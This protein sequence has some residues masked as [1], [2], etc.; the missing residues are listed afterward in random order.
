LKLALLVY[1]AGQV[2]GSSDK[3]VH[4]LLNGLTEWA[5]SSQSAHSD[6]DY[7]VGVMRNDDYY[8]DSFKD[9]GFI[10]SFAYGTNEVRHFVAFLAAGFDWGLLG[11]RYAV[12]THTNQDPRAVA[13][14]RE[15]VDLGAT[16]S[17]DFSGDYKKLAQDVWHRVCGQ[18]SNLNLP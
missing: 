6:P 17:S 4:G 2:W 1:K 9:T 5:T 11:G 18:S 15:A 14:G 16:F 8:A 12:R 10:K 3:I 7:R 13:L